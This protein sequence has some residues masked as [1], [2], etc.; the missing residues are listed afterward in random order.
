VKRITT[1]A[2]IDFSSVD[3]VTFAYGTNDYNAN[4][5]IGSAISDSSTFIGSLIDA[6]NR[7]VEKYPN[8]RVVLIT[9]LFRMMQKDNE[10]SYE[11]ADIYTNT[12]GNTLTDFVDAIDIAAKA[13]HTYSINNYYLGVNAK[14][15]NNFYA[16]TTHPNAKM[17][18][19]LATH[20][21]ECLA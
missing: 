19:I 4:H 2:S 6:A 12:N 14:N 7:L 1:L 18:K 3:I 11:S 16:D 8:L 5:I 9:P 13:I 20:I 21:A 15:Y 10:E 17:R